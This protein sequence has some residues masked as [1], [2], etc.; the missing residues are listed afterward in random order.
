MHLFGSPVGEGTGDYGQAVV[1]VRK[2]VNFCVALSE[3]IRVVIDSLR[4]LISRK[5][6]DSWL[7][8]KDGES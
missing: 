1:K 8:K 2:L 7:P 3:G 4:V 5:L 6:T